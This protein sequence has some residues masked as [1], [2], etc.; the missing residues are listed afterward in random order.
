MLQL[1]TVAQTVP[2]GEAPDREEARMPMTTA[3]QTLTA[4]EVLAR[5]RAVRTRQP[6]KVSA[7]YSRQL[8][9]FGG[10]PSFRLVPIQHS[11]DTS[12]YTVFPEVGPRTGE[13]FIHTTSH[14]T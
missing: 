11:I 6:D 13:S 1:Q 10:R 7:I 9:G 14:M 8:R 12:R 2:S 4:D 3:L 5:L